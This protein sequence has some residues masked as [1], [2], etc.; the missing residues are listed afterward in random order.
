MVVLALNHGSS[1]IKAAVFD[2]RGDTI[3]AG[4]APIAQASQEV[5][6][7]GG[8]HERALREFV[9]ALGCLDLSGAAVDAVGHRVVH[10]GRRFVESALLTAESEAELTALDALAPLHNG[11]S[12]AGIRVARTI[13]GESVPMVAV[14][15]TAFHATLP[16]RAWR[17]AIPSDFA[18]RH[19]ARR[20]GFH[21]V[22]Y[23]SVLD[24]FEGVA[25]VPAAEV[26]IIALHLGSGCS[27]AAIDHGR[28]IDT[29]MGLT[30][31]EGLVMGTRSG[32]VDPA[33]VGHLMRRE[34]VPIE[35]VEAWLNRRSGL[36]GL[37]G[38]SADI[39]VLLEQESGHP[40]ARLA[41][42]V[43]CYRARKVVGAYVAALGGVDAVVFTGGIGEHAPPIR[44]R[45]CDGLGALG[46][47]L[48]G[49][50]NESAVG[51]PAK[52]S[53]DGARV[54]VYVIPSDEE[55]VIAMEAARVVASARG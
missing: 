35:T 55:R 48:D 22:S 6:P 47:E 11:P 23:R 43:F 46:I 4:E 14:F 26:R 7:D 30:P 10:G 53:A 39:R 28:S 45:I 13:F 49:E 24:A 54:G 2:V 15:D 8:T 38:L 36:L 18:E 41:L 9:A 50:R 20:F 31:L 1:S 44:A 19:D 29:S 3:A 25:G 37:S 12:L 17:Y 21:G 32:D 40:G 34:R 27:A 33:L 51:T 5:T 52:I 42:E 16:E